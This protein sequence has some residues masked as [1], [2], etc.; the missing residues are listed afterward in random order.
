MRSRQER[1][2]SESMNEGR[3]AARAQHAKVC[4]RLLAAEGPSATFAR[5]LDSRPRD[6][7]AN[8][9]GAPPQARRHLNL[10]VDYPG[11][12]PTKFGPKCNGCNRHI[13]LLFTMLLRFM[14]NPLLLFG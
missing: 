7:G 9:D 2:L 8:G 1:Q 12:P 3:E 5:F 6:L 14:G 4:R 11:S 13:G 10:E